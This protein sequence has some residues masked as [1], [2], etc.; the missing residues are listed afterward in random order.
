MNGSLIKFNV[1][2]HTERC[3]TV[4]FNIIQE[5]KIRKMNKKNEITKI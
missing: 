2:F 1:S 3:Y 4:F 5:V